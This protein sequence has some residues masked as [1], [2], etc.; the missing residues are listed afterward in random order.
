M[1]LYD[2]IPHKDFLLTIQ[3]FVPCKHRS[4]LTEGKIH[5]PKMSQQFLVPGC[6][7]LDKLRDRIAC[8][9]DYQDTSSDVS[10]N[11][12]A[13]ASIRSGVFHILIHYYLFRLVQKVFN[14]VLTFSKLFYR[15][16]INQHYFI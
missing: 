13:I 6:L 7:T 2:L 15:K 3:V 16:N 9:E 1:D 12:L 11:P 14:V 8:K 5:V 10:Y 4:R